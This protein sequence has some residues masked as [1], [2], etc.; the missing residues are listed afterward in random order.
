MYKGWAFIDVDGTLIDEY[1]Q[2]RPYIKEL[3]DF[4]TINKVRVIIWSGGGKQYA[5]DKFHRAC[6]KIGHP[7]L[8]TLADGFLWKADK[9]EWNHIRPVWF[10]DDSEYIQKERSKEPGFRV[11][12]VPF[13]HTHTMKNDGWLLAARTDADVFF[14]KYGLGGEKK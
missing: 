13:Y 8:F 14:Q 10:V 4:L 11:F 1:D 6:I 2:P 12:K 5:E 7:E 3:I 9:I